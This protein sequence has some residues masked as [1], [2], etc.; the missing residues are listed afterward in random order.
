MPEGADYDIS[1]I[2]IDPHELGTEGDNLVALA[3]AIGESIVRI[4]QTA[5]ALK[6]GWVA[7]SAEQAHEF[8]ERWTRVM[9]QMFGDQ[10]G[11]IG[12]LPALAGGI[13]GTAIGFSHVEL[14]LESA[15][16]HMSNEL[17]VPSGGG[18]GPT[19]HTGPEFPITQDFPD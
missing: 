9:R 15:F 13:L 4:N 16:I 6:L 11:E 7:P 1:S 10:V 2:Q 8:S 5:A 12:V 14:E 17:A 18:T 3:G 19:D